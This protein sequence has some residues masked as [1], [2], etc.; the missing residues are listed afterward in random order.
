MK[1]EEFQETDPAEQPA[2]LDARQAASASMA[3]CT[4]PSSTR[5][6]YAATASPEL[7]GMRP[8]RTSNRKPCEGQRTTHPVSC[9]PANDEPACGQLSSIAWIESPTL[10]SA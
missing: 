9:P 5:T 6:G 4:R 7:P 10:N 8:L 1:K 2:E 3:T